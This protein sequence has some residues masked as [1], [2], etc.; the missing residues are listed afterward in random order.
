MVAISPSTLTIGEF[1]AGMRADPLGLLAR[2]REDGPASAIALAEDKRLIVA[3]HPPLIEA[4]LVHGLRTHRGLLRE[5]VGS[6][7]FVVASGE[8][9]HRRRNL[10]RP[11]FTT[12]A[13]AAHHHLVLDAVREFL[14]TTL[15]P[16]AG[17]EFD[18]GWS[19]QRLSIEVI[20][21]LVDP[22]LTGTPLRELAHVLHELVEY[23]DRR[24]FDPDAVA[25]GDDERFA[26]HKAEL[27][28][29]LEERARAGG[30][31]GV[32]AELVDRIGGADLGPDHADDVLRDEVLSLFVAGVETMGALLTWILWNLDGNR[33]AHS[34]CLAEALGG[35]LPAIRAASSLPR[36]AL[37]YTRA[38]VAESLRLYP[39]AWALF[40]TLPRPV[41][42]DGITLR[43][44]DQVLA[45]TFATHRD[46]ELWPE[47]E[48]FR[49]ERFTGRQPPAQQYFPFGAGPHQCLGRQFSLVEAQ[50][51]IGA[52]LRAGVFEVRS[53]RDVSLRP[54][55]ALSPDPSPRAVFRPHAAAARQEGQAG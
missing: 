17:E 19:M 2:L 51:T 14:D 25:D 34:L 15:V 35:D 8:Q 31:R 32:L 20:L 30:Q 9:W 10:L 26:G 42:V 28:A 54:A 41:E 49:P 44:G 36:T 39:P 55:I 29:F 40:R 21:R 6:G 18:L 13:V 16:G 33:A 1:N 4:A 5:L 38:A 3:F 52:L 27:V 53:D 23:L 22:D 47:P 12:R 7:L 48:E 45:A 11:L 24:L 46:P 50:L 37:P 43:E